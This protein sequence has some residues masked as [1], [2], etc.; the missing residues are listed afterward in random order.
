MADKKFEPAAKTAEPK[1]EPIYA[2]EELAA[3]ADK[4]FKGKYT[5]DIVTAALRVAGV[6]Q[7]TVSEAEDVIKKFL[8]L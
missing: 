6:K 1:T 5:Q 2:A 8:G 7:A 3:G 4:A